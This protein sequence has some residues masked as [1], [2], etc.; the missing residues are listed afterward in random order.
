MRGGQRSRARAFP[1]PLPAPPAPEV[2][3]RPVVLAHSASTRQQASSP[4]PQHDQKA[5]T[6]VEGDSP[7]LIKLLADHNAAPTPRCPKFSK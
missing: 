2:P 5:A 1:C 7:I 3:A 4:E 6:T